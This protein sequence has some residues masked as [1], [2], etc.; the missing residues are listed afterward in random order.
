MK[1]KKILSTILILAMVLTTAIGLNPTIVYAADTTV[2]T[3]DQLITAVAAAPT[4]SA[5]PYI[6]DVT[7]DLTVT[8]TCTIDTGKNIVIESDSTPRTI[9]RDNS[10]T[11]MVFREN[12]SNTQFTL[13]NITVDGNGG[14]VTA[15]DSIIKM[16]DGNF[17]MDHATIQN[18]KASVATFA[19]FLE[20]VAG[21]IDIEN[22]TINNV[23]NDTSLGY[24][25]G[26]GAI[27][28][29]ENVT[30]INSSITNCIAKFSAAI[31]NP[32][33]TT[34]ITDSTI[35]NCDGTSGGNSIIHSHNLNMNG[36]TSIT[37]N[38]SDFGA[39]YVDISDTCNISGNVNINNNIKCS[40]ST[41]KAN[42]VF[43]DNT[44]IMNVTGPLTNTAPIGVSFSSNLPTIGNPNNITS[45]G[46]TDW[47]GKFASDDPSYTIQNSGNGSSQ[48]VQ[49]AKNS[50]IDVSDSSGTNLPTG[51][52]YNSGVFTVDSGAIN[53]TITVIGTTNQNVIVVTD[54]AIVTLILNGTS[55]TA[56]SGSA[57]SPIDLKGNSKVTLQLAS[58]TTSTASAINADC[59]AGIRVASVGTISATLTITG[60]GILNAI[61]N[62]QGG[63]G[64]GG[65]GQGETGGNINISD[66]IVNAKAGYGAGI[67]GSGNDT[68]KYG[69]GGNITI[70][71]GT[72]NAIG[73][74]Y[75]AG[76]GGGGNGPG[77][78]GGTITICGS[79]NVTATGGAAGA[80]IGG[81]VLSSGGAITIGGS[82]TVT[83]TGGP[84]AAGIGGGANG[85][86]GNITINGGTINATS[87]D[88]GAGIGGGWSDAKGGGTITINGGAITSISAGSGAGI[89]GG[90][91]KSAGT[92]I[93]AG[94]NVNAIGGANGAG[95]GGG[96]TR[97]HGDAGAGGTITISGGNV[98]A[99]GGAKAAGIGGGVGYNGITHTDVL[100]TGGSITINPAANVAAV[101]DG[102]GNPAI[103][104]ISGSGNVINAQLDNA[105]S[106]SSDTYLKSNGTVLKLPANYKD[107]AFSTAT[108]SLITAYSDS[109]CT[110]IIDGIVTTPGGIANI[111][112]STTIGAAPTL[113]TTAPTYA[114]TVDLDGGNGSTAS[115]SYASGATVSIN[116][117]TKS[118][119]T[120][121]G[122][123]SSNG[124]TFGNASNASTTFA[125]PGNATTITAIWTQNSTGGGSS[126]GG[127]SSHTLSANNNTIV[128]VDN[129]DYSIGTENKDGLST[130]A[131]VDQSKLTE[132]IAKA[133]NSSSAIFPVS[134]NTNITA[135]LVVKNVE[136]MAKKD[137]TLTVQT[138]KVSYNLNTS[139]IDTTKITTSLGT[140]DTKDIP[141]NVKISNSN[142]VIN[143]TTIVVSPVE[144]T[145]TATYKGKTAKVDAFNSFVDRTIEITAEQAKKIT[146]GV[147]VNSDGTIRHVPTK[148][149][150]K[151]GK[152]YAVINSLTNSTYTVIW[153]P[154][155][156]KDVANH[157]AKDAVNNMGSRMIVNGI[158][159]NNYEPDRD[160]TRAE[161]AAI[162]VRALGLAPGTDKSGFDDVEVS[163][164]YCGYI[165][166]ASTYGIIQG[167]NTT[168]FGPND[169]ITREQAMTIIARAMKITGLKSEILDSE[170]S[171]LFT[172]YSDQAAT[173]DYAKTSIA[174]CLKT[175]VITGRSS[176]TIAPKDCITRAEV[177]VIVQRLLQKSNLI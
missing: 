11:S 42:V 139:A 169:A 45:A 91:M 138:G 145:I 1:S 112:L 9:K 54:S 171:S 63:A 113:V 77:A 114:L 141:F 32:I 175:G 76:I 109:N 81:G 67:G 3:W 96:G 5:I 59:R 2:N 149:T 37:N 160:I 108:A 44:G 166:T 30:I 18:V 10:F 111:P 148:V 120:F 85:A 41:K 151:D 107:F 49:L 154:L 161:F 51:V 16:F 118:G 126:S 68:G 116:A 64:I 98:N 53:S 117:G 39:V 122:W 43:R 61:G 172:N 153:N 13:K 35:A 50:L 94:G 36:N 27:N 142:A 123:T 106:S 101:S 34:N 84:S 22:S 127:G 92:I 176:A 162:I 173:S 110:T 137:M 52:T 7:A 26:G 155:E 140:T 125:M 75:G 115:S 168:N 144:F 132:D 80:G 88:G 60:T 73:A 56:P 156:F 129:K 47:S 83:A 87:G 158:G 19:A 121:N 134:A 170:M 71:G 58:G 152:Y 29:R 15:T 48:V 6:I 79:A 143:G 17:F 99:I 146:T 159:G 150:M 23:I 78:G 135:Q 133:S 104:A 82:A 165:E 4:D 74:T 164:W 70:S 100:G 105:I 124:G 157:W 167:Y 12:T 38:K 66:G 14:N 90:G 177:A 130:T 40:D 20:S 65:S 131:T 69:S 97:N 163:K 8:S 93:I 119:Y 103:Q 46:S 62:A 72:V 25:S 102:A 86:S 24:S 31:F 174:V 147:V 95:I 33:G 136:D 28:A 128:I 55:I 89:G 21:T 57:Y